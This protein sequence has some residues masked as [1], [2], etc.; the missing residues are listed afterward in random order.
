MS[1]SNQLIEYLQSKYPEEKIPDVLME[2]NLFG[3]ID[4]YYNILNQ[5][6]KEILLLN[7]I[8]RKCHFSLLK[9]VCQLFEKH[10]VRYICFKGIVLSKLLYNDP[11][12][13]ISADID[14]YVYNDEFERAYTL[15]LENGFMLINEKYLNNSHHIA[16]TNGK[17]L[18]ELHKR[19]LNHFT[20]IDEYYIINHTNKVIVNDCSINTF[21]I[22]ATFLHLIYHLYMDTWLTSYSLYSA[23]ADRYLPKNTRFLYRSYEIALFCEKYKDDINW[24]DVVEDLRKQRFRVIF[25]KMILDILEN[26]G[27]AIPS[28][29]IEAVHQLDYVYQEKDQLYKYL[30]DSGIQKCDEDIECILI[31]YINDNW[32]ARREK[33]ICKKVGETISLTNESLEKTQDLN[34]VIDTEK[35]AEGLK[36]VFRVSNDDFYISKI[37]DYDTQ[38]SD[39]VHLVLCGTEKYSYNSIFFFP[40]QIDGNIRIVVC[41]VLNNGSNILSDNLIK[42]KF[43]KT[44]SYYTI[45]A[46]LSNKFLKANNLNS[47]LYMGL[48][49]SDCSCKTHR[50]MN[51]LILSEDDSQWYNP[52]Y[53]A[54]IIIK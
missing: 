10:K 44:E 36:M 18:I 46:M 2:N 43:E 35:T 12:R 11:F 9:D 5:K 42:A 28:R 40:K 3:I 26:F 13:R 25:K 34:C 4:S 31:N 47:Y 14:I 16:I 24:D 8:W 21:T 7:T 22:T 23:L 52:I 37:G 38:T 20:N 19:I 30:I 27:E 29:F 50:R 53:F 39:G 51:Q 48:V 32:E 41:D 33:N 45:T 54:K 17:I 6:H 1:V 49:V 15:L